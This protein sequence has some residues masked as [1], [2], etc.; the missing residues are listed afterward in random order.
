MANIIAL[1][2]LPASGKSVASK[3]LEAEGFSVVRLGDSTDFELRKRGME[4]TE[5]NEKKV[6][7]ELRQIYG[8]DAYAKLNIER[9]SQHTQVVIDGLRSYEEYEFLKKRFKDAIRL[10]AID[11]PPGVR[12]RRM[13]NRKVRPL[14]EE[15]C[16]KRDEREL[17]TLGVRETLSKAEISI[18]NN[19][20]YEM[21]EKKVKNLITQ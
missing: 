18:D 15:E 20:P 5:E 8:N 17:D 7:E 6:R 13:V 9:I 4:V 2:G 16:I 1:V 3:I 11:A 19:C 10:V 12:H 14:T 21:F